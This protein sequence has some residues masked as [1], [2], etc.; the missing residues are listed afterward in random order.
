MSEWK[1]TPHHIEKTYSFEEYSEA[2][3]ATVHIGILAERQN[4]HPEIT[5]TYDKVTVKLTT[6][7]ENN[8]VTTKDWD[9]A[10][11]IDEALE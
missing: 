6:H 10:A 5:T 8:T 9:L 4:H 7:D 2:L 11:A 1:E 3:S